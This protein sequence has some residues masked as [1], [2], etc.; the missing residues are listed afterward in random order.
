MKRKNDSNTSEIKITDKKVQVKKK[1][2]NVEEAKKDTNKKK[3]RSNF[4][5]GFSSRL[6]LYFSLFFFLLLS[7]MYFAFLSLN[8]VE[9]NSIN[10]TEK[11]NL[12]Y[13]VYL[14]K[15]D[16]YENN[17]LGMNM[18][19]VANLI[20]KVKINFNYN[21]TSAENV[22][23]DFDYKI[24]GRLS[25]TD[26][27][28]RSVYFEKDY[29]LLDNKKLVLDN[30]KV[31]NIVES[32]DINYDYYNSLANKFKT[33]YGVNAISNFSIY[34]I[35]NKTNKGEV[36]LN[37]NSKMFVN[38]PLSE[39][40]V[41]I[42]MD[43]KDINNTNNMINEADV[44]VNN[45]TYFILAI[46]LLIVSIV[47]LI[48]GIRLLMC[49]RANK[50]VYDKYISKILLEYDR[51]IV[52]TTTSPFINEEKVI[53]INNFRELLDVRDNLK[54]PIMYYVVTKHEKCYFYIMNG[55]NLYLNVVKA[56]DL[57]GQANKW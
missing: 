19:Y 33:S 15:N 38:I 2:V 28:G 27:D 12:N 11:S 26:S 5:F 42:S 47:F 16:F 41:S 54:L 29:V 13:Q 32:I 55:S 53:K 43:Y 9:S 4:Y 46:I 8:F 30:G 1:K 35:V 7:A 52:E 50:S 17:Y 23:V 37:E 21:F 49:L 18:L 40:A 31:Q 51:V 14:K 25:I 3:T 56:V 24:V 44:Y 57:I 22:N 36:T 39:K 34:F 6:L 10:Y 45:I 48:K 20:D